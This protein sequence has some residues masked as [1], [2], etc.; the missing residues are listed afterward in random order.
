MWSQ[1]RTKDDRR[2]VIAQLGYSP[3]LDAQAVASA[4]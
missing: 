2:V 3:N 1:N 4:M